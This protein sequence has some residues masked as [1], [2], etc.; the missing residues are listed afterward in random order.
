MRAMSP[1]PSMPSHIETTVRS[2]SELHARHERHT[3][4]VQRILSAMTRIVGSPGFLG[5]LTVAAV[6]WVAGN[7]VVAA[8]GRTP[9]DQP[10]FVCFY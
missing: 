1:D 8:M 3:S 5:G 6:L 9:W 2:I 4:V 10:P 7:L